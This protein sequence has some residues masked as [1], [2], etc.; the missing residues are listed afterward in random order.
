VLSTAPAR[1]RI[2]GE[3]RAARKIWAFRNTYAGMVGIGERIENLSLRNAAG[4]NVSLRKIAPGEYEASSEATRFSYEV[5]IEAPLF[6]TDSAYISWLTPERGF[7]MLGDLL[8][9]AANEGNSAQPIKIVLALPS[10]WLAFSNEG[11]AGDGRFLV[12]DPDAGRFFVGKDLRERRARA[13]SMEFSLVTAGD[14]AFTDEEVAETTR[15]IL[16]EHERTMGGPPIESRVMLMLS[17]YPR[18]V[19]AERWSA[20]TRGA[21]VVLLSGRQPSKVAG[22]TLLTTPLTHELFHLWVPNALSLDGSYDWFYEGFTLYQAMRTAMRLGMFTFNDYLRTIGRANDIYL[23]ASDRDK[24]SLV[25]ASERRWTG[26]TSLVY[27]K[28]MLMAFLYDLKLREQSGGKRSLD[29]VY[30]ELFRLYGRTGIRRDGNTALI[31]ALGGTEGEMRDFVRHYIENPA[32]IDLRSALA[33]YG[34]QIL[35]G[36]VRTNVQVVDSLRRE[37]RDLLRQLGYNEKV[38]R[39]RRSAPPR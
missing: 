30:R 2:E 16:K 12:N 21:N 20:E 4:E 36:G 13:G 35:P 32:P 29:N 39:D 34:L 1:V 3:Q 33:A 19:G 7:L 5:K 14:W 9:R 6:T 8:P 31:D 38:E 15:N 23:S 27:N 11:R 25:E 17:P 24:W 22:L 28:G 10:G 26:A 18:S 37:Q